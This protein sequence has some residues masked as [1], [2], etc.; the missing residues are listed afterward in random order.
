M[1]AQTGTKS[2]VLDVNDLRY[3]LRIF[4]KNWYLVVVAAVLSSVLCY[5]YLYKQADVYGAR[6]QI[7]LKDRQT[8]NY[9]SQVY[10]NIG[11]IAAYGDI[12]NQKRVLTSYDMV[13]KTL[14]KLD[15]D[16]SYYVIGRFKTTE[17]YEKRPFNV[18]MQ[19][20]N[21]RLYE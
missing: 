6:T 10:E 14:D 13:S 2:G 12:V 17:M 8:Y 21:T 9:Q 1:A 5:L 15:F 18:R 19:L 3:F 11:Y 20:I 16:V 4:S 7:L